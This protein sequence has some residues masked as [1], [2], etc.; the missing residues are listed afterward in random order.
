MAAQLQLLRSRMDRSGADEARG[1]LRKLTR[2]PVRKSAAKF[3]ARDQAQDTIAQKFQTLV[4][5]ISRILTMR[6]VYQSPFKFFRVLKMM[7]EDRFK[8]FALL[9]GHGWNNLAYCLGAA[10]CAAACFLASSALCLQRSA[11][12]PG[13]WAHF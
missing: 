12:L 11:R 7:S 5:G 9:C 10:G 13:I 1:P 6:A 4:I 8:L 2:I 3:F